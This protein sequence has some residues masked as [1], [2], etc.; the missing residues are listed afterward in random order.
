MSEQEDV[1]TVIANEI[2]AYLQRH[3]NATDTVAGIAYWW[4]AGQRLSR[5]V[6]EVQAALEQLVREG[7]V[8]EERRAGGEL[9]Y[10]AAQT[11]MGTSTENDE[12]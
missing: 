11:D 2:E 3:P 9:L 8:I 5:S 1:V 10:R 6:R 7:V 12:D 4:W